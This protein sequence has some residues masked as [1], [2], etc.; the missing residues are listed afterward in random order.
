M[1]VDILRPVV[2]LSSWAA[3]LSMYNRTV[4]YCSSLMPSELIKS[5]IHTASLATSV[6]AMYSAS[7]VTIKTV[8]C[9][10]DDYDDWA[11]PSI[12]IQLVA[13]LAVSWQPA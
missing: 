12:N 1:D 13:D 10:F 11:S 5:L 4:S 7:V 6:A 8:F 3:S 9:L 2:K